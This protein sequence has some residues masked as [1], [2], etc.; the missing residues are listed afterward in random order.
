MCRYSL[1]MKRETSLEKA[2]RLA[3]GK[4]A[5]ARK[6]GVSRQ[7]VHSW[8]NGCFTRYGEMLVEKALAELERAA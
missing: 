4:A 6:C 2:L 1:D 3:G 5:L 8:I 7:T